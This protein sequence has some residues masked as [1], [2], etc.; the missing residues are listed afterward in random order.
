MLLLLLLLPLPLP[1]PLPLLLLLLLPLPLFLLLQD[2]SLK[3]HLYNTNEGR[4]TLQNF[5]H[6]YR[7]LYSLCLD[8]KSLN[9]RFLTLENTFNLC[10]G[11]QEVPQLVGG[12]LVIRN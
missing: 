2:S 5:H 6:F 7:L 4:P 1:L 10:V 11:P 8:W 9:T 12:L 3:C